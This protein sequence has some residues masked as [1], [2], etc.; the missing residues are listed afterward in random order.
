MPI[1]RVLRL[2]RGAIT[3]LDSS[4]EDKVRI[5]ANNMPVAKGTVVVSGNRMRSTD[6]A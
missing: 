2:A 5:L 4:E 6:A 1:H 3:E